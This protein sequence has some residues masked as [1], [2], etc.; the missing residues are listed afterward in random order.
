MAC[1]EIKHRELEMLFRLDEAQ[2]VS[3][4]EA[5]K[6]KANNI[7]KEI[8][9]LLAEQNQNFAALINGSMTLTAN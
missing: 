2:L 3:N 4:L 1:L 8:E 9:S 7:R 6:K 5:S